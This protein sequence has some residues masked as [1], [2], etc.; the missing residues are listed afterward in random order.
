[1]DWWVLIPIAAILVGAF[2]EWLDFKK[3]QAKLG[4]STKE[5][6]NT[7]AEQQQALEW[8]SWEEVTSNK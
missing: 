3:K 4:S 1:M 7:V 6:E 5:L 2:S 8:E